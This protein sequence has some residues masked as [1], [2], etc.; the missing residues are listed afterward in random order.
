MQTGLGEIFM[1][2][3]DISSPAVQ[4]FIFTGT[5]SSG[6]TS[7]IRCLDTL[8]YTVITESATDVILQEQLKKVE[9]PWNE[10]EFGEKIVQMQKQR[11]QD[12]VGALQFYDRSPFCTY[13]LEQYLAYTAKITFNPSVAVEEEINRCLE[14]NVYQNRVFFFENF[15]FIEHTEA[16]Q[17]S[18]EDAVIFE[19][20]HKDVY[21][22]FGFEIINVSKEL[23]VQQRCAFIVKAIG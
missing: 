3:K 7:V 18:Y 2:M 12:A 8:G 4:R 20:M 23:S 1:T 19:K 22:K 15:G 5:P 14:S 16:R 6:K 13:A 21:E 9:R 10:P 17:I 11:Q